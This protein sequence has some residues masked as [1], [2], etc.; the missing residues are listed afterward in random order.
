MQKVIIRSILQE[1]LY[2]IPCNC[3]YP[4]CN[5][6]ADSLCLDCLEQFCQKHL[7]SEHQND[8]RNEVY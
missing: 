8:M 2:P 1:K 3:S 6:L 4:N 7:K 5:N